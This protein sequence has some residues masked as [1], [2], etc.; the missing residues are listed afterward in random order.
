MEPLRAARRTRRRR[1]GDLGEEVVAR[2]LEGQG[3]TVVARGARTGRDEID[4][5][6]VDPAGGGTLVF[7]EVRARMTG[8][9]GPPEASVDTDKVLRT[10]RG[11]LAIVS[12]AELPDGRRL[13]RLPWRVDLVAA[14][15]DPRIGPG[16]GGPRI[17][18]LRGLSPP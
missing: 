6:A 17:R 5:V 4:I 15:L 2:H 16:A 7:V 8:R 14:D 11:A 18:H 13:P 1:C 10:Y 9:F 3:W 12:A